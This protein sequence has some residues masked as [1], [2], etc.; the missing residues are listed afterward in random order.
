MSEIIGREPITLDDLKALAR[1]E[2]IAIETGQ[3]GAHDWEALELFLDDN[4][5]KHAGA[6]LEGPDA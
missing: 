1:G 5:K 4:A 6:G 2:I 3:Y